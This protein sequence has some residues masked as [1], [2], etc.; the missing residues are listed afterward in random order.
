MFKADECRFA[1]RSSI[2]KESL[3]GK[4]FIYKVTVVLSKVPKLKLNYG[5]IK[6]NLEKKGIMSP[7][8]KDVI[9]IISEIRNSKLPNPHVLPNAGSF[10]K[11]PE[12]SKT[13]FNKLQKKY[14]E[15][16]FFPLGNKI[17]IPAGW[18]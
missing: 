16:P 2:F 6:E 17:K 7:E 9:E 8:L 10:F 12:I 5:S 3:K 4:Y 13:A 15:I 18:L 11:N 1:Y 14:P